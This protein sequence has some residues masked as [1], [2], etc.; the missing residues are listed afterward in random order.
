MFVKASWRPERFIA[1]E[2]QGFSST[3]SEAILY[4]YVNRFRMI[5]FAF[6][7]GLQ[8]YIASAL[9]H[10]KDIASMCC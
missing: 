1:K 4:D 7:R 3:C 8:G 2:Q 10:R 6:H 9:Q 5:M